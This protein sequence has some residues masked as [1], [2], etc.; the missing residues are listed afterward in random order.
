MR[1]NIAGDRIEAEACIHCGAPIV[2]WL[3]P[4]HGGEPVPEGMREALERGDAIMQ[5]CA[6]LAIK[7]LRVECANGHLVD[8]E[9]H[10]YDHD[11]R[12]HTFTGA[13]LRL[14]DDFTGLTDV[15]WPRPRYR[16][17]F[18]PKS[19]NY[20]DRIVAVPWVTPVPNFAKTDTERRAVAFDED[21]CQICGVKNAGFSDVVIFLN[22]GLHGP[23]GEPMDLTN[24]KNVLLRPTDDAVMHKHC[25]KL[26][27][28]TCPKLRAMNN[29]GNLWPFVGPIEAVLQ[30]EDA[31]QGKYLAMTGLRARIHAL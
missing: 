25:A 10:D 3:P 18:Q 1:M 2:D 22:G 7:R 23:P 26:A 20:I 31:K 16:L 17:R 8:V 27:S 19:G 6:P 30:Y 15:G 4:E 12:L 14:A 28:E 11:K 5:N 21:L 29:V 13:H 24:Y 9:R